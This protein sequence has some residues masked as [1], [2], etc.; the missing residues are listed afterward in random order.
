MTFDSNPLKPLDQTEHKQSHFNMIRDE[1]FSFGRNWQRFLESL[2]QDRIKIAAQSLTE[3]L[4]LTDLRGKSFLDIGCGSGLFSYAAFQLGAER[5]VS[6]DVDPFSV[7]C[8]KHL[9]KLADS[10]AKWEIY[11]GSILGKPFISSLGNFDIVYS[12][13]V[14]HHTGKMWESILNSCGLVAPNGYYYI[15]LYNKIISRNGSPAWI[16][17]FWLS[18][19]K[20]YNAHPLIGRF[21]LEPVAMSA[22]LLMVMAR[23]DNPI[24]HVKNYRSHRGMRWRTD[25][26]DWIGGY[27]YEFATVEEVFKFVRKNCPDF[28]LT[29]IKTTSGRGLNWYAFQKKV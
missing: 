6:F 9:H 28:V 12:W 14:L 15:A 10:P 19:K 16:H 3:F 18:V 27:P 25:A 23:F 13:G 26:T 20:M 2:D 22:Y 8:C 11:E 24:T 29:N 5:I 1:K 21:V 17:Q 4:N 7:Q